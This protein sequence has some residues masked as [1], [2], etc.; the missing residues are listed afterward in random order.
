MPKP[1]KPKQEELPGVTGPGVGNT[2]IPSIDKV[3]SRWISHKD[4]RCA[5]LVKEKAA[6]AE[7]IEKIKESKEEIGVDS[8][9]EIIYRYNDQAI[10][11]TPGP[12]KLRIEALDSGD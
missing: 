3:A 9:G 12:D 2:R 10:I 8:N 7:L 6:K 4:D 5:A 11:L 1:T